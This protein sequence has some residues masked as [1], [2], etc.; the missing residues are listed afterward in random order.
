MLTQFKASNN[1]TWIV[2]RDNTRQ[3]AI[4]FNVTAIPTIEYFDS[5]GEIIHWEQGVTTSSTISQWIEEDTKTSTPSNTSSKSSTSS[6]P[7][8]QLNTSSS[9]ILPTLTPWFEVVDITVIL[10]VLTYPLLRNRKK[11]DI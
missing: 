1:M 9:T 3:G 10:F 2:G 6:T 8:S 5:L 11:K 4:K 7:S